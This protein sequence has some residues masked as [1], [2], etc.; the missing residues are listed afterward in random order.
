MRDMPPLIALALVERLQR[1]RRH[2]PA[3]GA[4]AGEEDR[5]ASGQPVQGA[6]Q[7]YGFP[8]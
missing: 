1:G 7:L 2:R 8:R 3:R 4:L 6:K 5:D